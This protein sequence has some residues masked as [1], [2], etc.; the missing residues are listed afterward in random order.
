MTVVFSWVFSWVMT[1][2]VWANIFGEFKCIANTIEEWFPCEQKTCAM[3]I[4]LKAIQYISWILASIFCSELRLWLCLV[5]W[6]FSW[7]HPF[8]Y[9][10]S[11]RLIR[12][13]FLQHQTM[14]FN[15]Y[16]RTERKTGSSM[17][18]V[19]FRVLALLSP[20][21]YIKTH[22][23]VLFSHNFMKRRKKY[24]TIKKLYPKTE[25]WN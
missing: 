16:L 25:F 15:Q 9:R 11:S 14:T 20:H 2:N 8:L 4:C 24:F 5:L 10:L 18:V 12:H 7:T 23:Y 17:A 22:R 6:H 1:R 19:L 13:P 3:N 21:T